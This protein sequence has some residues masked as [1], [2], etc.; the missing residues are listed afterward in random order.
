MSGCVNAFKIP[1]PDVRLSATDVKELAKD[2]IRQL[3]LPG[4]EDSPLDSGEIW[5]AVTLA[6]VNQTSIWETCRDNDN[7]PCDNTAM[8]WL[9]TLS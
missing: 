5:P 8:D 2:D 6:A 1:Q 9:H 4:I 3:M 7:A